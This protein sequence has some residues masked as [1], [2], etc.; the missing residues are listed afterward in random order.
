MR[1]NVQPA[2]GSTRSRRSPAGIVI[3]TSGTVAFSTVTPTSIVAGWADRDLGRRS[4]RC[5]RRRVR[6]RSPARRRSQ[7]PSRVREPRTGAR[8]A[9]YLRSR[10][11]ERLARR[12]PPSEPAEVGTLD[13]VR[14]RVIVLLAASMALVLAACGGSSKPSSNPT[15]SSTGHSRQGGVERALGVGEDDLRDRGRRPRSTRAR[16]A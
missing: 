6:S 16:P 13:A 5:G 11:S 9:R 1:V 14:T 2:L 8:R 4:G 12:R 10:R 15:T 7:R 3:S